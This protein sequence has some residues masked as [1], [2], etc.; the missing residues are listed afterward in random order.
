MS[1]RGVKALKDDED[2]FLE[3]LDDSETTATAAAAAAAAVVD[4][5]P[6]DPPGL[7]NFAE[8]ELKL[9]RVGEGPELCLEENVLRMAFLNASGKNDEAASTSELSS[10][11]FPSTI[12]SNTSHHNTREPE[13]PNL[14]GDGNGNGD[15]DGDGEV[16]I[17]RYA[18]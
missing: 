16:S 9:E 3:D 1:L 11:S 4:E 8:L 7:D 6:K 2:S 5:G 18:H 17:R 10:F 14:D 15:G 13:S 12:L